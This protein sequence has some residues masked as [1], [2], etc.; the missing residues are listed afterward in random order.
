MARPIVPH[1]IAPSGYPNPDGPVP[2]GWKRTRS[3]KIKRRNIVW[4]MRRVLVGGVAIAVLSTSA[5]GAQYWAGVEIPAAAG[6]P[7]ASYLCDDTVP[8]G[9]CGPSTAFAELAVPEAGET[10]RYDE[11]PQ[12][13]IDA[14]VSAEDKD[15]F[16]HRGVDPA[17]IARAVVH[18]VKS[19]SNAKQGGSTL[20][21]QLVKV[22]SKDKSQTMK[23][24]IDEAIKAMKMEESL[25]KKEIL[26]LYLNSV[27]FGRNSNG[28]A[29]AVRAYFGATA[30]VQD[31]DLARASYLAA[32]IREPE[33]VD[34]NLPPSNPQREKQRTYATGRRKDVLNTMLQQGYISQADRDTAA[35]SGWAMVVEKPEKGRS[36]IFKGYESIGAYQWSDYVEQWIDDNTTIS[37]DDLKSGGLRVYTSMSPLLQTFATQAVAEVLPT[38]TPHETGLVSLDEMGNIKAM[39]GG[40]DPRSVGTNYATGIQRQV[41]STFKAVVL[42]NYLKDPTKTLDDTFDSPR[43]LKI[44]PRG[45]KDSG[46]VTLRLG[47]DEAEEMDISLAHALAISSNT[48]LGSVLNSM[49][50]L[51]QGGNNAATIKLAE[52]LGLPES[53]FQA[54]E[55]TKQQSLYSPSL[56]IGGPV[57]SNPLS[58]AY[59]YLTLANR[60]ERVGTVPT[61]VTMIT[62]A[63][64]TKVWPMTVPLRTTPLDKRVADQVDYAL[65]QVVEDPHG[66]GHKEAG[67]PGQVVAGKTGTVALDGGKNSKVDV[68]SDAWFVGFTCKLTAAVWFGRPEG[69]IPIETVEGI[70][71]V[72]GGTLPA[73]I[74]S[75]Y[76]TK[77]TANQPRCPYDRPPGSYATTTQPP[78]TAPP[79]TE[80]PTTT[81]RR[82]GDDDDDGDPTNTR[83]RSPFPTF[84]LPETTDRRERTTT[85]RR[86]GPNGPTTTDTTIRGRPGFG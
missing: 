10:V 84:T 26:A 56:A 15:F 2:V 38:K 77:A 1:P 19:D 29:A 81:E 21:Q 50:K 36:K 12:V 49:N 14:L 40:R 75:H 41:G 57:H 62:Q 18:D 76:M 11:I 65:T 73:R 23:R 20:T 53:A 32:V 16:N 4:R 51:D 61:P 43:E 9:D 80:K 54:D 64:G 85:S 47:H 78:A 72:N 60:G 55:V 58:M 48:A 52:E 45:Y 28:L 17:G 42:A 31:I 68:N 39:V 25:G 46:A 70:A 30:R 59:M 71:N 8:K 7:Q 34:A 67:V 66:T 6:Q 5:A 27:Y 74:F 33:Y 37:K 35:E 63:D 69:P 86:T 3:G 79:S 83:R 24:K 44:T 22:L 82:R 13:M